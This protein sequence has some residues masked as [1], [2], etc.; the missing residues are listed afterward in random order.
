MATDNA[1][2]PRLDAASELFDSL[3]T[4]FE[5]LR[6]ILCKAEDSLSSCD[7]FMSAAVYAG[8]QL[9]DLN[10]AK[11]V[12]A[13]EALHGRPDSAPLSWGLDGLH[14]ELIKTM[15]SRPESSRATTKG[16]AQ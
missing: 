2:D 16:P 3:A 10:Y 13:S 7:D 1:T 11:C 15:R 14:G 5:S 6:A 9:A 12:A 4:A 8:Y